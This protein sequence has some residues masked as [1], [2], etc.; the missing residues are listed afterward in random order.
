MSSVYD[1]FTLLCKVY[2]FGEYMDDVHYG[3]I[4]RIWLVKYKISKYSSVPK[5]QEGAYYME[6]LIFPGFNR[7]RSLTTLFCYLPKKH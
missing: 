4:A 3:A 1:G 2:Y 6:R 5:K 7:T